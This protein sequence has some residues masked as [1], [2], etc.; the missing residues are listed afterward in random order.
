[1]SPTDTSEKG[2]ETLIETSLLTSGYIKGESSNYNRTYCIDKTQ[3]LQFLRTTQPTQ[4]SKLETNYNTRFEEKLFQ[5]ISDQIKTKGII[6]IL[7]NGIKAGE[8][9][10]TLYY[11]Q[12]ASQL[13]PQAIQN[14]NQ[15]I[16][17]FTRQLHFSN[18]K[19]RQSLDIVIFIN[20]LPLITF[21]LKNN[22]TQ[23]NVQN[24]MR[25]YQTD[26]DPKETLFNFSRC[27]VHFAVDDELVYMT[28]E[29]KKEQTIFL[30]FN[31]GK[32]SQDNLLSP[33]SAGNPVNHN[34]IKTDYLWKEILTKPSLSNI[35]ENYA[36]LVEEKTDVK[37]KKRKLIFPRYHQLDLVRKL[38][39]DAKNNGVGKRYLVQHSAGSGKSNSISWL[40]H[41]LVE[42]TDTSDTKPVFDS[43]IVV[44]DRKILD[45]QI[46]DNIKQFAQVKGVVE[47]ITEGSQQLKKALESGKKIIITNV[48]K[49]PYIVNEIQSLGDKRFAIVIDEA[50]SS[51]GGNTAA[52]MSASL[53]KEAGEEEETIEDKILRIIAEQKLSKNASYF[54]FTATPKNKTLETFGIYNSTDGKFYPFHNYSMKQAIEEEF[55]LDVLE[56]YTTYNSYYKL[57]KNIE[58]D[59]QFDTK[60]A[61][62]KLK[63]YVEGHPHAIR[64]KA[65]IM[66]DH[67]LEDVIN[68]RKINGQ[69]KA[70]VVTNGIISAI[71]YKLA[72]DAYLREINSPYKAIVAFSG[73]KQ[74]D[75]KIEDESSMNHFPGND[76]PEEFKKSEYRFLIVADKYQTGFDQPLLHTMYVDKILGDIKAVQTLSRLNRAYKPDKKD[77]FILDFVNSADAIKASFDPFYQT[78]ILSEETDINR[79]NDLQD[80]LDRFQ[81]YSE[82]Q[83]NEL[84]TLFING[85]ERDQLDPILDECK[86]VFIDE[87]DAEQQIDFKKKAKSFVRNYQFLV[88][89]RAFRNPYWESLK[90]FLKFLITKLPNLS[91]ADLSKGILESIDI[92][93]YRVERETTL[94]IQLEGGE[95]LAPTPPDIAGS[96]YE[97]KLDSLSNIVRD[98]N[99]R[100]GN[101]EWTEK[102]KVRRLL[103]E[104]LPAEISQD[105]EYQNAK[106]NSDRQNA[107]ITFEKKLV[108][109]FQEIIFDQEEAYRKFT[110]DSEFKTWLS[111]TL[112]NLDYDQ[113]AA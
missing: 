95:E 21:E 61:K 75:G 86:Q 25:Q 60:R 59:P 47:A 77:T 40:S 106:Q 66:I 87:L 3:L 90:T 2:L 64:Q 102:D 8:V 111:N 80:T 48:Y 82:D 43:I 54:A 73:S 9:S 52:K 101:I 98:F 33:D 100:F 108:D 72:F 84:M 13:N 113:D 7:R 29:L 93:S 1:M 49:F 85:A 92:D 34:G 69:A 58:N 55:I 99:D 103:F 57:E 71:R 44:T 96:K 24:A 107:K 14:Y 27:L 56:N 91:D 78:T 41:Q 51:Q 112:F 68:Q 76:I 62:K 23:Q 109:K 79:L 15:N 35:I 32:K 105:E 39:A 4:I 16:F 5:R 22:L 17:S 12:P 42:L 63:Q 11:K 6:E 89:I 31:K 26:R 46:R 20:G 10:L 36:Q 18:D 70:M 45:K 110:E 19:K 88:Q 65:E 67:F 83:V 53:S 81:V 74:V 97:P 28:T 38:L 50:H 30:P 94:A 104:E 37:Q